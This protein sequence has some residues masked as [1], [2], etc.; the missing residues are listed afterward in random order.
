MIHHSFPVGVCCTTRAGHTIHE[1]R[2]YIGHSAER[3]NCP[4]KFSLQYLNLF[5]ES[6]AIST[7]PKPLHMIHYDGVILHSANNRV[8]THYQCSTS[9]AALV[10]NPRV[11][12][13]AVP[14]PLHTIHYDG[15]SLHS[16]NN[17]VKTHY[18][19]SM[20]SAALVTN[21]WVGQHARTKGL[22]SGYHPCCE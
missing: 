2:P 3:C 4:F 17:C 22:L 7:V 13:H 1:L 12:R 18:Q 9:S 19:C 5:L 16:A 21:L 6:I 14:K 20:P 8:K 10:T 15:V 11:G